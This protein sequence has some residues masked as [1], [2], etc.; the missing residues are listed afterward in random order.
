M[1]FISLILSLSAMA[2]F[3]TVVLFV[4]I[5]TTTAY[6]YSETEVDG[7]SESEFGDKFQGDIDLTPEQEAIINGTAR[8]GR[9]GLLN[10]KYRWPKNSA[11]YVMVPYAF[12]PFSQF[13]KK[14]SRG[15][16]RID[17]KLTNSSKLQLIKRK[18]LSEVACVRSK[19]TLASDSSREL[20]KKITFRSSTAKAAT[21]HWVETADDKLSRSTV[22][23]VYTK[24]LRC[25]SS[26]TLWDITTC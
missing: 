18:T 25:T 1:Q 2:G 5:A 21:Q 11:G 17:R 26:S 14:I 20:T 7:R 10:T 24:E 3:C 9:T 23:D 15:S 4:V 13:S 16:M 12:Q 19:V 6:P 8:G 22:M